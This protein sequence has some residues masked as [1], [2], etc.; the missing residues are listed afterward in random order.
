MLIEQLLAYFKGG[1][2]QGVWF[3]ISVQ[4]ISK[5][6][7][8]ICQNKKYSC[9]PVFLFPKSAKICT[10]LPNSVKKIGRFPCSVI[11]GT[12]LFLIR[13]N[14][15]EYGKLLTIFS[16]SNLESYLV[17]KLRYSW[18]FMKVDIEYKCS[19]A[20]LSTPSIIK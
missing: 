17:P 4:I 3:P 14:S 18:T 15:L 7:L 16:H 19:K 6:P 1:C 11:L 8:D 9:P 12:L 10:I 13:I 20:R 2:F 5:Y